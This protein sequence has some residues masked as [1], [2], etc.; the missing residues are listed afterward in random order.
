MPH[1]SEMTPSQRQLY[2]RWLAAGRP[3]PHLLAIRRTK[4][5]VRAERSRGSDGEAIRAELLD[6]AGRMA[7]DL[8]S[9]ERERFPAMIGRAIDEAL[10]EP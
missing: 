4:Q 8:D 3:N 1:V 7:E 10:V 5:V 6:R 2:D 9:A